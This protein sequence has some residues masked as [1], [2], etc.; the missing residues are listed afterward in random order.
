MFSFLFLAC[1]VWNWVDLVDL[2]LFFVFHTFGRGPHPLLV[3]QCGH[4]RT[5]VLH[6]GR[7][8]TWVNWEPADP[9]K[10]LKNLRFSLSVSLGF[11]Y[12]FLASAQ[13]CT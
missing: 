7:Y 11:V 12:V 13:I 1:C 9:V 3:T 4:T 8:R 6:T 5:F 10:I 2:G